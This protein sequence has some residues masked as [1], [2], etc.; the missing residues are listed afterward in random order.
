MYNN[1]DGI[2]EGKRRK[3][4]KKIPC[5]HFIEHIHCSFME[6]LNSMSDGNVEHMGAGGMEAVDAPPEPALFSSPSP[7]RD[8]CGLVPRAASAGMEIARVRRRRQATAFDVA[9]RR[10]ARRRGRGRATPG[11]RARSSTRT[12]DAGLA[13]AG[14]GRTENGTPTYATW[15]A[16]GAA[17]NGDAR[18]Q[19][20]H[21]AAARPWKGEAPGAPEVGLFSAGGS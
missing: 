11:C 2:R 10:P 1:R 19:L 18:S 13:R 3:K 20:T 7:Q 15:N 4:K 5:A 6:A 14:S 8:P 16:A 12:R 9:S 21:Q 17:D